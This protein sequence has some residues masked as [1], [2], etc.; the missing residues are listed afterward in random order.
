M[1]QVESFHVIEVSLLSL[2]DFKILIQVPATILLFIKK[3]VGFTC[4]I[5]IPL[6]LQPPIT[7]S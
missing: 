7:A 3:K 4:N 2:S 5:D 6:S 1:V